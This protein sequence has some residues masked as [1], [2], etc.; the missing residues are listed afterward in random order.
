LSEH[1]SSRQEVGA[2]LRAAGV[3]TIELRASIVIGC[4]SLSC[5]RIHV[6]FGSTTCAAPPEKRI[7]VTDWNRETT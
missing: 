7:S 1:L 3:P 6:M 5:E 4:G 2:I